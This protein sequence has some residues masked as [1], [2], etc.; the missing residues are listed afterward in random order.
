MKRVF[1]IVPSRRLGRS[2][3][4]SPIPLSTCSYSCVYCQL[5]RTR[6]MQMER[7]AFYCVSDIIEQLKLYRDKKEL[8]DVVTI[9]GEGEP[10]LY[11]KL[12]HLIEALKVIF[13]KKVVLITNASLFFKDDVKNDAM[14]ADIVMPSLD[15]WDE[16]SFK[17]INRPF[18]RISFHEMYDG[19]RDFRDKYTG[20]FYLE[21]MCINGITD[22]G[23]G[24]ERLV[25]KI[26]KLVPDKVFVNTP[27]RPPADSWV[28][29]CSEEFIETFKRNFPTE[30]DVELTDID[31]RLFDRNKY[32][33]IVDIIK[34]HPVDRDTI[35]RICSVNQLDSDEIL[36]RM[37]QDV[38]IEKIDYLNKHFFRQKV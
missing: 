38:A 15:A 22:A 30:A 8:F 34:R 12:G 10:T 29:R 6:N 23:D 3:G 11:S 4:V 36:M 37:E 33:A 31:I 24:G 28:Q 35:I 19:L 32:E 26:Q 5:G 21:T 7:K 1:G 14:K 16:E 20:E 9:V 27:V 13:N 25:E 2:L 17:K 18:G